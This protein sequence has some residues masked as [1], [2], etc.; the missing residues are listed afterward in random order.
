MARLDK[1]HDAVRNAL[2]KDGWEITDDPY[3][4]RY[5]EMT[6]QAD[7]AAE[8]AIAA[9]RAG[10][11]IVVEIKSFIGHSRTQDFKLA[12]GQYNLYL[13]LLEITAPE[14]KLY[15]AIDHITY[16]KYFRPKAIE[17]IA[18]R[19]QLA[20]LVVNVKMEE[21]VAWIKIVK[22][23]QLLK[24]ILFKHL[25][26][27]NRQPWPGVESELVIDEARDNYIW[28]KIGWSGD[29]RIDGITFCAR[30][31]NGKFWIEEDWTEDGIATDLVAAGVPKEDIVL[32]FQEPEMRAYT[33]FAA[34]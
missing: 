31:R 10:R 34:A 14:R 4:I 1:I 7:L 8:R 12:L 17:V 23:R 5:E 9:E 32:A 2:I 26:L 6:L 24:Q 28:I 3:T 20:L 11:K 15:L 19:F 13:G 33:E 25:E 29:E 22:Y 21:I 27:V 30:I 16:A 18:E